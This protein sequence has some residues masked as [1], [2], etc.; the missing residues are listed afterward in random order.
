MAEPS[1]IAQAR[2][3]ARDVVSRE[4]CSLIE[5]LLADA[6]GHLIDEIERTRNHLEN[7]ERDRAE[8]GDS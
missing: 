4:D 7:L 8:S 3:L 1:N 6:I 5:A 2:K